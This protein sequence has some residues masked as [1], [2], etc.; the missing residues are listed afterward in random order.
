MRHPEFFRYISGCLMLFADL[1][2]LARGLCRIGCYLVGAGRHYLS[3]TRIG[4]VSG[5]VSR[6]CELIC[7]RGLPGS[8]GEASRATAATVVCRVIK[9][10]GATRTVGGGNERSSVGDSRIRTA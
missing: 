9:L 8:K 1:A 6:P 2:A 7:F 4:V 3:S 5:K 10:D